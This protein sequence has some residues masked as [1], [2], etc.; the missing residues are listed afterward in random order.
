MALRSIVQSPPEVDIDKLKSEIEEEVAEAKVDSTLDTETTA[1]AEVYA[2]ADDVDAEPAR[3]PDEIYESLSAEEQQAW[4]S[5]WRPKEI[6]AGDPDKWI[7]AQRF[8]DREPLFDKISHQS[9]TIKSQDAKIEA[10][11][12][13]IKTLTAL[14]KAS[15]ASTLESKRTSLKSAQAEAFEDRDHAKYEEFT[16]ELSKIEEQSKAINNLDADLGAESEAEPK[17]APKELPKA[18]NEF[19]IRNKSWFNVDSRATAVANAESLKAYEDAEGDHEAKLNAALG[20]AERAVRETFPKYFSNPKKQSPSPV[21]GAKVGA[22]PQVQVR[23]A[24]KIKQ[25]MSRLERQIMRE[26]LESTGMSEADYIK[27]YNS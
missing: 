25:S 6:F 16:K 8:M 3:S 4:S 12:K 22:A 5:G 9:K 23:D 13:A 24:L 20:A 19:V 14:Q 27:Q 1:I 17:A 18:Y 15:T 10:L 7:D 2:V 21:A 26:V 11:Q